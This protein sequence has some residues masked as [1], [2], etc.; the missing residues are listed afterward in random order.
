MLD[1]FARKKNPQL[2]AMRGYTDKKSFVRNDGSEVLHGKDWDKRK[3]ELGERCLGHCE[4]VPYRQEW[5][6]GIGWLYAGINRCPMP[7]DDPHHI[8]PRSKGRDDRLSNLQ[9]LCRY[10]HD[11]LDRR[12]PKWRKHAKA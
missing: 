2:K 10:H 9:A 1:P 8:K 6:Q 7:A 11:L 5:I 4:Y 3:W 12:K